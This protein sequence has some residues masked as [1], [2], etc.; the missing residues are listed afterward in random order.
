MT[1]ADN[2]RAALNGK[3]WSQN[4]LA[5]ETWGKEV[6]DSKGYPQPWGKDLISSYVHGKSEPSPEYEA[7]IDKVFGF[8]VRMSDR[9]TAGQRRWDRHHSTSKPELVGLVYFEWCGHVSPATHAKML[10]LIQADKTDQE[11]NMLMSG[12]PLPSWREKMGATQ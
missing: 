11:F 4:K 5:W 1:Y 7:L 3:R 8:G 10:A 9:P 2:L 12:S 6:R